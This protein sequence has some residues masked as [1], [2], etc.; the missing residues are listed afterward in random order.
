MRTLALLVFDTRE[1]SYVHKGIHTMKNIFDHV[2]I[3]Q[4]PIIYRKILLI[5]QILI[6]VYIFIALSIISR[7]GKRDMCKKK[8]Q[9]SFLS[10]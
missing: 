5:L 6:Q 4:T 7:Y 9:I 8:N 2:A 1:K 3:E 10:S